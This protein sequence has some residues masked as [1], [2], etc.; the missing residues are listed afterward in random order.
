[1]C[2]QNHPRCTD[3]L[4]IF[5]VMPLDF[6]DGSCKD[7]LLTDCIKCHENPERLLYDCYIVIVDLDVVNHL[8]KTDRTKAG[9]H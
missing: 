4:P 2:T 9:G 5:Y 6:P 3:W 1:M 7:T 8:T